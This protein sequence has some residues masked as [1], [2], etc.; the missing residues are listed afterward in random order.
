MCLVQA[1]STAVQGLNEILILR[2]S[3]RRNTPLAHS[4]T[5]LLG[6]LRGRM[7]SR[8]CISR[9]KPLVKSLLQSKETCS[10]SAQQQLLSARRARREQ[11]CFRHEMCSANHGSRVV[12]IV[13]AVTAATGTVTSTIILMD[14]GPC[15]IAYT[16]LAA[17][18]MRWSPEHWQRS[19]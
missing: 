3:A 11:I 15:T 6:T 17:L 12:A 9:N 1:C 8:R 16:V 10:L 14:T 19:E 5:P 18:A 7:L 4:R 13:P 2:R